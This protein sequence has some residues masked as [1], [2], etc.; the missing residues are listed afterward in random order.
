[1]FPSISGCVAILFSTKPLGGNYTFSMQTGQIVMCVQGVDR[2]LSWL[3]EST[4][5]LVCQTSLNHYN[6]SPGTQLFTAS[7]SSP[8]VLCAGLVSCKNVIMVWTESHLLLPSLRLRYMVLAGSAMSS[9]SWPQDLMQVFLGEMIITLLDDR[10]LYETPAAPFR[11]LRACLIA[12]TSR[13]FTRSRNRL[14]M[15]VSLGDYPLEMR[16]G[17]RFV[18]G[19]PLSFDI[20]VIT[21]SPQEIKLIM[22]N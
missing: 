22:Y 8:L 6:S 19:V 9:S 1:M 5:Y 16:V 12:I 17:H 4:R 21:W 3:R 14:T 15:S 18:A 2:L 10:P 13:G 11:K 20:H 7:T